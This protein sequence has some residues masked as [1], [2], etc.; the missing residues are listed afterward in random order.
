MIEINNKKEDNNQRSL[1]EKIKHKFFEL[2][3]NMHNNNSNLI[4]K[5]FIIMLINFINLCGFVINE[6][7]SI[8]ISNM[9]FDINPYLR[10][11]RISY[12]FKT[13]I[14]IFPQIIY[15]NFSYQMIIFLILIFLLC[16]NEKNLKKHTFLNKFF[17]NFLQINYWILVLPI[18]DLNITSFLLTSTNINSLIKGFSVINMILTV[19]YS[20]LYVYFGNTSL[21][22]NST[23][24]GFSR[25]DCNFELYFLNVKI[26]KFVMIFF[27]IKFSLS[28]Y[29][30]LIV[31]LTC[32]IFLIRF[33]YFKLLYNNSIIC[34]S[35]N[36]FLF[37]Y[38]WIIMVTFI[39]NINSTYKDPSLMIIFGV[40]IIIF[41]SNRSIEIR[42][43]YITIKAKFNK[44][45]ENPYIAEKYL[46]TLIHMAKNIDDPHNYIQFHGI[47]Y[48]HIKDCDKVDCF[49]KKKDFYYF[50][51]YGSFFT[52]NDYDIKSRY[53]PSI[54]ILNI[55]KYF[56][57]SKVSNDYVIYLSYLNYQLDEIGN[58]IEILNYLNNI[59]IDSSILQQQFSFYRISKIMEKNIQETS[60]INFNS[61]SSNKQN[62]NY[63]NFKSVLEYYK[64]VTELKNMLVCSADQNYN[65]WNSFIFSNENHTVYKDG[66]NLFK[67]NADLDN[68]FKNIL[69]IYEN[70]V[71]LVYRY[72]FYIKLIRGDERLSVKYLN[73][74]TVKQINLIDDSSILKLNENKN[75]S[76]SSDSSVF[77]VSFT[78]ERSFIEK[79][80]DSIYSLLGYTPQQLL[81]KEIETCMPPF[82]RKRH[83]SF[84][85]FH[86]TTGIKRL[87]GKFYHLHAFHKDNYIIPFKVTM[88]L[89]PNLE[90]KLL[91]MGIIQ[92]EF[93]DNGLIL[94]ES[95]GKIDSISLKMAEF[96]KLDPSIFI[97]NNIYIY[98]L[99]T[100]FIR[101]NYY[102]QKFSFRKINIQPCALKKM[103]FCTDKQILEKIIQSSKF[104]DPNTFLDKN[105]SSNDNFIA[106][107]HKSILKNDTANEPSKW[108]QLETEIMEKTYNIGQ[109]KTDNTIY[110]FNVNIEIDEE[111]SVTIKDK[112]VQRDSE[113][114]QLYQ[115]KKKQFIKDL[116]NIEE[117]MKSKIKPFILKKQMIKNV[118]GKEFD[119]F[120]GSS[121]SN[122][123]KLSFN[124]YANYINFRNIL[125]KRLLQNNVS[126]SLNVF[127][128]FMVLLLI[129]CSILMYFFQSQ[130]LN[131][132]SESYVNF[133]SI[134]SSFYDYNC[135]DL[136]SNKLLLKSFLNKTLYNLDLDKNIL[137]DCLKIVYNSQNNLSQLSTDHVNSNLKHQYLS[138]NSSL[139][140]SFENLKG[141]RLFDGMNPIPLLLE[142]GYLLW[143]IS[144]L[145][146]TNFNVT[147]SF[148]IS[149]L[150]D[151]FSP[152]LN[153]LK[154]HSYD[155]Y[156]FL[157]T[158]L[159]N[160]SSLENKIFLTIKLSIIFLS[161]IVILPILILK[162]KEQLEV[163]ESFF[164]IKIDDIKNQRDNCKFY[165]TTT[166]N[167]TI[168]SNKDEIQN[169]ERKEDENDDEMKEEENKIMDKENKS[170]KIAKGKIG[171]H[172]KNFLEIGQRFSI[173]GYLIKTIIF[174]FFVVILISIFPIVSY[175]IQENTYIKTSYYIKNKNYVDDYSFFLLRAYIETQNILI[176]NQLIGRN[177]D[178]QT[179]YNY[180]KTFDNLKNQSLKFQNFQSF[181]I[182]EDS[183]SYLNDLINSDTCHSFSTNNVSTNYCN[184]F[185]DNMTNSG[186]LGLT[187]T[188]L[189]KLTQVKDNILHNPYLNYSI[190]Y[191]LVNDPN[192]FQID[193]YFRNF[194]Y[195]GY[196]LILLIMQ[197][198]FTILVNYQKKI[199]LIIL[200]IFIAL[201]L[202]NFL[203]VWE[204]IEKKIN[205]LEIDTYKLF[206]ILPLRFVNDYKH[207][208]DYLKIK[209]NA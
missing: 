129:F 5:T 154:T 89:L 27:T 69:D 153:N 114:E 178:Y 39:I 30:Y 140:Q 155:I 76:F 167:I 208:L 197:N 44:L 116:T 136:T 205:T 12:Y 59:K 141:F 4:S 67:T 145:N 164:K 26:L 160:G 150:K 38:L 161:Y 195:Y 124:F 133:N 32:S 82:F 11:A 110:T 134:F 138:S 1:R 173:Q 40:F 80:S 168:E 201:I 92:K 23:I 45:I 60:Y 176:I 90:K 43:A 55:Y 132:I 107:Y 103:E 171:G 186:L 34:N 25:M 196:K 98:H 58:I 198:Y 86:F 96:L 152:F 206:S 84:V 100:N 16:L 105:S 137:S 165:I 77:V 9:M 61:K 70:D 189:F 88:N 190:V 101:E 37:L 202:I 19:F 157:T 68:L 20:L 113:G 93:A 47:S 36:Y 122:S 24:E 207:L 111:Y 46:K 72:S 81:G 203:L 63:L 199:L 75:F 71:E 17:V 146:A 125:N 121:S 191:N 143:L 127:K 65:F 15:F 118:K 64:K 166:T 52:K 42:L 108:L 13:N 119:I 51:N 170:K 193:V 6:D 187:S 62:T 188:A 3:D 18:L 10:I 14:N 179:L 174:I 106:H 148:S 142:E 117:N 181:I 31:C 192:F 182:S 159:I 35:F 2:F 8:R 57:N 128:Y 149:M 48:N 135:I 83:S 41:I 7:V 33:N 139:N 21:H 104:F 22:L 95:N 185:A 87:I 74:T 102:K 28:S 53:F 147:N 120:G 54:F 99:I 123:S 56:L 109:N 204:K 172:Q 180:N 85:N 177:L 66:L 79:V 94:V 194:I 175:F 130:D 162:K 200:C 50:A 163:L 78:K 184:Y 169:E 29:Y 112:L 115:L 144:N 131:Q 97:E 91:Y 151:N 126:M 183:G 156:G 73:K 209:A 49:L 158:L